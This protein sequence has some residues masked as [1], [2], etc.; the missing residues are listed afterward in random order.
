VPTFDGVAEHAAEGC[1][2]KPVMLQFFLDS[3][4]PF[5]FKLH[6]ER[7]G[8]RAPDGWFHASTHPLAS[9]HDLWAYIAHPEL[10]AEEPRS[11]EFEVAVL[12]GTILHGFYEAALNQ[13]GVM[14][15]LPAGLCP[16]CG[17]EYLPKGK[18]Q[19][20]RYCLEH[21]AADPE[22]RSRCHMDGIL[23]FDVQGTFGFDLKSIRP[24]GLKGISDMDAEAFRAKWP[25]YWAQMQEC[26]RLSGLRRYIVLFQEWGTPWTMKEF[27]IEFDPVFAAQT[28]AKYRRV[29]A[30]VAAGE[31][32]LD[33]P[34]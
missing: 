20:A 19:S 6:L 25:K 34:A 32:I 21:G 33:V 17:R 13:M 14:V 9:E 28:E 10:I 27:H 5:K 30:T 2:V 23:N 12:M 15:P 16:S 18:P 24:Y 26:M 1:L 8:W 11:Y 4:R 22:T 3:G 7:S 29:L 31:T